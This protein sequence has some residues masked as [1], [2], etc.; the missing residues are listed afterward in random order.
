MESAR[1]NRFCL[2]NLT[3]GVSYG[4]KRIAKTSVCFFWVG[5]LHFGLFAQEKG[6]FISNMTKKGVIE[7][8]SLLNR[9]TILNEK[10]TIET[11]T[12]ISDSAQ[13]MV[14]IFDEFD[15]AF[16][17]KLRSSVFDAMLKKRIATDPEGTKII[18]VIQDQEMRLAKVLYLKGKAADPKDVV[19]FTKENKITAPRMV[20]GNNGKMSQV[21]V[22]RVNK[23]VVWIEN[24]KG[25]KLTEQDTTVSR[26]F[27]TGKMRIQTTTHFGSNPSITLLRSTPDGKWESTFSAVP[28]LNGAFFDE[29]RQS[30]S[31][32]IWML[33]LRDSNIDGKINHQKTLRFTVT[34]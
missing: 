26:T 29:L 13:Y 24:G 4:A 19:R 11:A 17:H 3:N 33:V 22:D 1:L 16:A 18:V 15:R 31:G 34:D 9:T 2:F 8:D 7:N 5:F 6:V 23:G 21:V 32:T 20:M 14:L 28:E 27:F 30:D 10:W 25:K 12:R